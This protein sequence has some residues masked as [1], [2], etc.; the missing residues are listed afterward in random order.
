RVSCVVCLLQWFAAWYPYLSVTSSNSEHFYTTK[1][2]FTGFLLQSVVSQ[3]TVGSFLLATDGCVCVLEVL[4][5]G[6][7]G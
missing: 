4:L 3:S 6:G 7:G 1:K 5:G 2:S